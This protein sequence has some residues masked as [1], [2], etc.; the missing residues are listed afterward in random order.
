MEHLRATLL[1]L[2]DNEMRINL[3]K[4]SFLTNSVLFLG[5]IV[6]SKGIKVDDAK[7]QVIKDWHV[8]TNVHE[9][10]SFRGLTSFYH[11]F[12]ISFSSLVAQMRDCIRKGN[13]FV[14]A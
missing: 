1:V 7:V 11:R 5:Y 14:D 9:V 2:H 13:F 8:P 3:K 6:S 12:I 10:H 4:C